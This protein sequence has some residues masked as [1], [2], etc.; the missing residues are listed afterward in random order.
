MAKKVLDLIKEIY[1]IDKNL[2]SAIFVNGEKFIRQG[3]SCVADYRWCEDNKTSLISY[4]E[5]WYVLRSILQFDVEECL[6]KSDKVFDSLG[7]KRI[8]TSDCAEYVK[9][10][11]ARVK[12][13]IFTVSHEVKVGFE[14]EYGYV[15]ESDYITMEELRAIVIKCSELGWIKECDTEMPF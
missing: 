11:D 9:K 6:D 2:P 5:Q 8:R 12:H 1:E 10:Y 15:S 4:F 7:Y 14:G 13:I 3:D